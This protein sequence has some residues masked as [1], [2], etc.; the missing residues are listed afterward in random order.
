MNNELHT[1]IENHLATFPE[2]YKDV[3]EMQNEWREFR[4]DD[5]AIKQK[6]FLVLVGFLGGFIGIGVWVGTIQSEHVHL[7]EEIQKLDIRFPQVDTR[8][9]ALEV[10]NSEIKTRLTS[11]EVTLQEIKAAIIKLQ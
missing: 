8:L 9:T 6:A 11:I 3:Q 7:Q 1:R 5:A 10:N 2:R 4:K